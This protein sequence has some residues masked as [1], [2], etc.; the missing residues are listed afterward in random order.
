MSLTRRLNDPRATRLTGPGRHEGTDSSAAAGATKS[1]EDDKGQ[2][3]EFGRGTTDPRITYSAQYNVSGVK[4]YTYPNAAG[5]GLITT[6][7]HP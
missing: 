4:V 7:V 2:V 1:I 6:T 3:V 5:N